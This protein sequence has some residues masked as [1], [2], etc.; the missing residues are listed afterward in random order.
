MND[1]PQ[2]RVAS[3]GFDLIAS[4]FAINIRVVWRLLF[5]EYLNQLQ[6]VGDIDESANTSPRTALTLP[7]AS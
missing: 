4:L 6:S 2:R 1:T 7:I 5:V 3:P